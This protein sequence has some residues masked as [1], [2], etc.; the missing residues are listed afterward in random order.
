MKDISYDR[1]HSI[2][3]FTGF[4]AHGY[5][6]VDFFF[7]L[8]GFILSYVYKTRLTISTSINND[9]V[10]KFYLARFARIYPLHLITLLGLLAIE[11]SAYLVH[12]DAADAF[13]DEKKSALTFIANLILMH[14]WGI[15]SQNTSW[16]V[17][18]WSI[19]TEAA[20]YMLFPLIIIIL[21][22]TSLTAF[23][24]V[25]IGVSVAIYISIFSRYRSI[26]DAAPLLRCFGGFILGMGIF[27]IS[28]IGK[29]ISNTWIS[30]SQCFVILGITLSMHLG[31]SH[32][33]IISQFGLLIV[34]TAHDTGFIAPILR[35]PPLVLLGTL[36]YSIYLTH[37]LVYRA[38]WIYGNDIFHG[39]ASN[40]SPANVTLLK[41]AAFFSLVI[42][43]SFATYRWVEVPARI[44]LNAVLS[45]YT[46]ARAAKTSR[47][48]N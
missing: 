47:I 40:Y 36:S 13:I 19:S 22:R 48:K 33:L 23:A 7:I 43:M 31:L 2:D 34:L 39:L 30:V 41:Y 27:S 42:I 28:V 16:N 10:Y 20:C 15:L 29:L 24:F 17:P 1:G 32:S 12:S 9:S 6:W 25:T 37:W 18:S 14:G 45:K 38:Y 11:I 35:T 21:R 8:S 26:E 44:F 4:F 46:F 5:L 3:S